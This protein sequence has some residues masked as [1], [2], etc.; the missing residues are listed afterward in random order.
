MPE[1]PLVN[2]TLTEF[3]IVKEALAGDQFTHF[4]DLGARIEGSSY[5]FRLLY[6]ATTRLCHISSS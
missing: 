2:E 6:I 3:V 5:G 4:T 1:A